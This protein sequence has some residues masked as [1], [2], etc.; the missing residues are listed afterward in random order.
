M[1]AHHPPLRLVL[2]GDAIDRIRQRL[3]TMQTELD[4]W[5]AVGRDTT[6]D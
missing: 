3:E 1:N 5:D 6:V 2:G 4:T